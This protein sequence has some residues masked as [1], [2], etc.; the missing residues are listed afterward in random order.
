MKYVQ[1]D[2]SGEIGAVFASPQAASLPGYAEIQDDDPR[3]L[4]YAAALAR[5]S[6]RAEAREALTASDITVIR[7]VSAGV[8]VP[9]A[10]NDYRAALR[11]IA[12]GTDV[13]SQTLPVAPAYPAGT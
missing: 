12:N 10:W 3:W 11:A 8:A 7:C 6:L 1:L 13:Q 9:S 2:Q 4:A 5:E